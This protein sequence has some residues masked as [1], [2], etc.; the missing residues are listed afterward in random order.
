MSNKVFI[1]HGHDNAMK[2]NVSKFI[3]DLGYTPVILHQ[4]SNRGKTIIEKFET[5]SDV[6]FA[7]I[8]MS[9]DD[10]GKSVRETTIRKRARQNVV[11][12]FGYFIGKL[13]R[14]KVCVLIR[15]N[16]EKPSDIDGL[17]YINYKK[18]QWRNPIKM[19][20]NEVASISHTLTI[21]NNGKRENL[22]I[23]DSTI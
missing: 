7:I 3:K 21:D 14:E 1:V 4:Q 20:L 11:F 9:P 22:S 23:P 10:E 17:V 15:D 16:V 5:N 8:L 12:E 13:G 2:N 6:V 18:G 19:E